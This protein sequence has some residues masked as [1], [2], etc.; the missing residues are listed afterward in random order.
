MLHVN[1][2]L[3][4]GAAPAAWRG[5]GMLQLLLQDSEICKWGNTTPGQNLT[6]FSIF[7]QQWCVCASTYSHCHLPDHCAGQAGL[8]GVRFC[9]S[10]DILIQSCA[11]WYSPVHSDTVLCILIQSSAFSHMQS[12]VMRWPHPGGESCN[13]EVSREE[14]VIGWDNPFLFWIKTVNVDTMCPGKRELIKRR[15]YKAGLGQN[16]I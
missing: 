15:W 6:I 2:P 9:H 8:T 11:F 7:V 1:S 16:I 5:R 13:L 10:D 3:P 14:S 4:P 12:V